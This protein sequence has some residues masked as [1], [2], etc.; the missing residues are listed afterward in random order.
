[1]LAPN[2]K[3]LRN[4]NYFYCNQN[5][6][7]KHLDLIGRCSLSKKQVKILSL[8]GVSN[9]YLIVVVYRFNLTSCDSTF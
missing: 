6:F 1:M 3:G 2:K 8:E 4:I 7:A 5:I 9:E